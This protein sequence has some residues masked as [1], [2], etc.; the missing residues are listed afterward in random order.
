MIARRLGFKPGQK[1]KNGRYPVRLILG[2]VAAAVVLAGLNY[3]QY[4]TTKL[5]ERAHLE[6]TLV[7]PAQFDGSK[8]KD[9]TLKETS[10]SKQTNSPLAITTDEAAERLAQGDTLFFDIRETGEN[11]MGTLPGATHVRFPDFL[12][13]NV[14]TQGKQVVLFCHNGNRSSE[15]CA[16]LAKR[17]ID[18]RFIAGG[19]EKW[20]VE[21]R[22]FSDVDVKTLSD[23]RALPDYPNSSTLLGTNDFKELFTTEDLQIVDTRYPGDFDSGHLPG[24][25]NIPI[26][27]LPTA[28]LKERIAALQDKPTIAAC[29]DRRSCFMAQVLGL[30]LT[31]AGIDFQ[32]RYTTPW[33]YFVAPAPKPHVQEWLADQQTGLWDQAISLLAAALVWIDG[34][35]GILVGLLGLSLLSRVLVL[36]IALKS[37]RD[38]ILSAQHADEL[39]EIKQRLKDD[40]TR[41]ARAMQAFYARY[42]MTPMRNMAALLF[43]PVMMLGL[44]ATQEAS[45]Q[46]AASFLWVADLGLP[47]PT[48][49]LP[50][51]FAS[52][53]GVYLCWAVAKTRKQALI[54][55]GLGVPALLTMVVG[56]SAAGNVYL[57]ISLALLLVQR[58]YVVGMFGGISKGAHRLFNRLSERKRVQGVY[59][60]RETNHLTNSGNKSY[61]L[62]VLRNAGLPVPDGVVLRSDGIAAYRLMGGAQK[63]RLAKDIWQMIGCRPCAVRSSASN[64]DGADQSFAGVFDSMLDVH[65]NGMRDAL[66]AVVA[67]FTSERA[68]SY[69]AAEGQGD[70]G[71]ILVQVMIDA[72]YAGVLFTQDPQAP[73]LIMAEVVNGCGEDLVSGRV[74]PHSLRFGRYTHTAHP[75]NPD[76]GLDIAPLLAMGQQIED[77][78]GAPQDIEWA[79]AKGQFYIVQSRDITTLHKGSGPQ[80]LRATQWGKVLE[81]FADMPADEVV[82]EQDEMSEVLPQPTPLSFS[83]M[84]RL[85]AP[86][87]SVDLACRQL[88]VPYGL[89]EGPYGHLVRLFGRT[90]VDRRLKDAMALQLSASKAK[91]LRKQM[92]P[93]LT[94][95]REEVIP[96]LNHDLALWQAVD[97]AALP[98]WRVLESI[99]TLQDMLVK[100]VYV[101][102]EKINILAGFAQKEAEGIMQNDPEA[103]ARMMHA[104]M[105]HAPSSLIA[106][107]AAF[108]ADE[109]RDEA[110]RVMGH[111]SIFDYEL[112]APSYGEA[113]DLLWPLLEASEPSDICGLPVFAELQ[114]D[115][116]GIAIAYQDMKEQAKHEALRI[117]ALIR[118]ALVALG[119]ISGLDDLVFQLELDEL[120]GLDQANVD[121]L[122]TIAQERQDNDK[123]IRKFAPDAVS[124]TLS[125]CEI[126]SGTA[127][128]TNTGDSDD[129]GGTCVAGSREA[130]GRVFRVEDSM[131]TDAGQFEWF[132][133][134]DILVCRMVNPAWLPVVQRAGAVLSEVGG[135][136]SHMAIVAREKDV[137]MLVGCK[138]LGNLETGDVLYVGLDGSIQQDSLQKDIAPNKA[139]VNVA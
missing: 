114:N 27:A 129:M 2:L 79:Y 21:G 31:Q 134:G 36:P 85:W 74:T 102:A 73:G 18:C 110:L 24:A 16:E 115:P 4:S 107:C 104:N 33:E 66:D 38:Q 10:F 83:L 3:W 122:R 69:E 68:A 116:V 47:D 70:M 37:E 14:A 51:I 132:Q 77:I 86:G 1:H 124:L 35:A 101:E 98:T 46:I 49:L 84:G 91:Q 32:G 71:N 82:L 41:K 55:C 23:L 92:L 52:L 45:T 118:R 106:Q 60:L 26:R 62:S 6:A 81:R 117:V 87:G 64:E 59:A 43:L 15:T 53:A 96:T 111:R 108:P 40:P 39:A 109:Q 89:P 105:P 61:R 131:S 100:D 19:I 78:F 120:Q 80:V 103:Q 34:K 133:D 48:Y 128:V 63:T 130:K 125:D 75:D 20:I 137:T 99:Q 12:Q 88:G 58:A 138:G 56:L 65:E 54:W 11:A 136:L 8:I 44:S 93:T 67:S 9:D 29:Y 28:E 119:A 42:G 94:R 126:L 50:V 123:A 127:P 57:C 72:E 30:E 13:S 17:G 121:A 97:F 112:S 5:A 7:R 95:F 90:Y 135:F 76:A 139:A 25:I 113:P 22:N